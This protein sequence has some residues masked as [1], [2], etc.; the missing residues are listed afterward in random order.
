MSAEQINSLYQKKDIIF[1][2]TMGLCVVADVTKLSADKNTPPIPY[3]V[4][5]SYYDKSHVA[6][7][8]VEGHEVE[9]RVPITEAE[10][11]REFE[12]LKGA[13]E[14]DREY[15]PDMLKVGELAYVYRKSIEELLKDAGASDEEEA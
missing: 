2:S 9:L 11:V 7:I 5:K 14:A 12:A 8:P 3:Y 15:K 4:L 13:Y 6:Y 10:A 1:S